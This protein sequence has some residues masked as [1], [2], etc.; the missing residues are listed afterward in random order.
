MEINFREFNP[1]DLWI[2]LEFDHV[3]SE[4]EKQYVEELFNSWFYIGKLGGFNAENL[5][6]QDT[7]I[8]ISYLQ[9]DYDF[10]DNAMMSPMHNMGEFEYVG[11]WGRCWFDL[12]T[13]DLIALDVLI[14]SLRELAKE[15]VGIIQLIIGGEN[16][17]WTVEKRNDFDD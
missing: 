15:Y 7:G 4:M 3:P 10:A 16:E 11:N 8:D 6:I 5:Q 2:W 12:G 13:S 14:N 9:Y 17:D 1:F